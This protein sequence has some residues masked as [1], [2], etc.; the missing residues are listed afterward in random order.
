[1][2]EKLIA[3]IDQLKAS[4]ADPAELEFLETIVLPAINGLVADHR[5]RINE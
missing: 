4:K 1:M 3:K 2:A 5:V